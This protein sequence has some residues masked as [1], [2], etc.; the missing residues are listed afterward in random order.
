MVLGSL[1][2]HVSNYARKQKYTFVAG[3]YVTSPGKV[4]MNVPRTER[5]HSNQVPVCISEAIEITALFMLL[6]SDPK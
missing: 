5:C 6:W 2:L 4:W 3:Q 1:H